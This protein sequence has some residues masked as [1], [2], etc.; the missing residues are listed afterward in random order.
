MSTRLV[1]VATRR[2]AAA[3]QTLYAAAMAHADWLPESRRGQA[4]LAEATK[5]E[6]V[7]ACIAPGDGPVGFASVH[8]RQRFV[9]LLFVA[10]GL[11]GT[12][13]GTCLL[14]SLPAHVPPP[15][16][17]KCLLANTRAL[18]FYAK[19]GWCELERDEGPDGAFALLVKH[20][21]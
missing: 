12:G 2:D 7:L 20:A 5:G 13:I 1:R 21:A 9:H 18:R 6:R 17:L 3:L 8:V 15:W 16:R 11:E 10:P 14:A 4:D 19:N